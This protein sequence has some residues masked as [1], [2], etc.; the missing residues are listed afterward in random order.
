[1]VS[2]RLAVVFCAL[3]TLISSA[4]SA[5]DANDAAARRAFRLGQ[6][7]YE[8]GE[9]E[10]AAQQF[11]EAYRLSGRARLLYNAYLAY[12]DMQDLPNSART[13]RRFLDESTDLPASERDQLTARLA[14]I[15]RA[16]E[17]RT[18]PPPDEST[19][20]GETDMGG[21]PDETTD[22][23][24]TTTTASSG[25]TDTTTAT[26]TT[27][28]STTTSTGGG[29]T[30]DG[31]G[32][33]PSPVGFIVAGAGAALGIAAIITGVMSS[34]DLSTLENECPNDLCPDDPALRDAQSRGETLALVTDVLWVTGVVAI[35]AGVTLIFV[36]Q[37]GG[38]DDS[39]TAGMACAPEG[40]FGAVQGRF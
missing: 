26:T 34:S 10:Q 9:F 11:E 29:T 7:H 32:F 4:A 1:M 20:T 37:E 13:L 21:E 22:T 8:N 12:R 24:A 6:A 40:C 25:T 30:D 23:T 17:R 14:A 36:L 39:P 27:S 33:N 16:M 2:Y 15:E 38:D 5:Q 19:T 31:G 18:A 35:A 3:A 28:T